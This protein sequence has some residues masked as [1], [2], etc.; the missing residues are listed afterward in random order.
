[1]AKT[2]K[3]ARVP[4]AELLADT[5][6]AT[7][8]VEQ[9]LLDRAEREGIVST[10][11]ARGRKFATADG[12]LLLYCYP[13]GPS[14]E[15]TL[16][17]VRDAVPDLAE[18]LPAR[19]SRFSSKPLTAIYP[20]CTPT[21]CSTTSTS[22]PTRCS[23]PTPRPATPPTPA[24]RW[25]PQGTARGRRRPS[26]HPPET[27]ISGRVRAEG[28]VPKSLSPSIVSARAGS[29]VAR[30]LTYTEEVGGSSPSPPS[31]AST[32]ASAAP[33]VPYFHP[34]EG[35]PSIPMET[36]L[37]LMFLKYRYGLGYEPLVAEVADSLTWRRFCRIPL[38]AWVPHATTLMKI[39]T[40]LRR[41]GGRA[42]QRHAAA[43][44][45]RSQAGADAQ[46]P[47]RHHRHRADVAY[48]TD[49]GLLAKAITPAEAQRVLSNAKRALQ[50]E[51]AASSGKLRRAIT[52]LETLVERTGKIITQTRDSIP[53]E[54]CRL[55][56]NTASN[57]PRALS[58][59]EG[60]SGRSS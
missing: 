7:R 4:Y 55:D 31:S 12:V 24:A 51:G 52:D 39:T 49:S 8:A 46:G 57:S 26:P 42:A 60:S 15:F 44:G 27:V 54:R 1:V 13:G 14:I 22:S 33:F 16:Q 30:A 23:P 6:P 5:A 2:V 43:A 35:R 40:P 37:R 3:G 9:Q 56:P 11:R 36:Y 28:Q 41:R 47:R 38:G 10:L 32:S 20:T 17:A 58:V 18:E 25:C 50:A 21:T 29:S 45:G 53:R 34:S 19:L 48:P 59:A